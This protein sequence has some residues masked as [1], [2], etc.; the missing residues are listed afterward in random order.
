[1][2]LAEPIPTDRSH[3]RPGTEDLAHALR[4]RILLRSDRDLSDAIGKAFCDAITDQATI[5]RWFEQWD[6]VRATQEAYFVV[7][8]NGMRRVKAAM[9]KRLLDGKPPP[10]DL[11]DRSPVFV[12]VAGKGRSPWHIHQVDAAETMVLNFD[13][14]G[15]LLSCDRSPADP[16]LIEQI[17]RRR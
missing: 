10:G 6:P 3:R 16:T 4:H 12:R 11:R 15:R 14:S 9:V 17:R 1:V 5:N 7:E 2:L 13:P 8:K